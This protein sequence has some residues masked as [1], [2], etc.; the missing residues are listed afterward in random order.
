MKIPS[1]LKEKSKKKILLDPIKGFISP[2]FF[3]RSLTSY[4]RPWSREIPRRGLGIL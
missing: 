4:I 1:Y 2:F 3:S